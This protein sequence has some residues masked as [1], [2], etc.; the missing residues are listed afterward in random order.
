MHTSR[1][2]QAS[3]I[4]HFVAQP[5]HT[6]SRRAS[7]VMRHVSS[8]TCRLFSFARSGPRQPPPLSYPS[9]FSSSS[10]SSSP[11]SSSSI[12]LFAAPQGRSCATVCTGLPTSLRL[13]AA[14][15]VRQH[16]E[17]SVG[18]S[19]RHAQRGAIMGNAVARPATAD[20]RPEQVQNKLLML[21]I[22]HHC[23]KQTSGRLNKPGSRLRYNRRCRMY[24]KYERR[25]VLF[26]PASIA[27]TY[28]QC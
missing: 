12:A 19:R 5:S 25:E 24:R 7:R 2:P 14:F 28:Y 3:Q 26:S 18:R 22:P 15:P 4:G 23:A 1:S 8:R 21:G 16:Q 9:V 6:V 20:V 11:S 10:S 13:Y 27:L 17:R